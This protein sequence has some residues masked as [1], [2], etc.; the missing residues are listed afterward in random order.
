MENNALTVY[1]EEMSHA[2]EALTRTVGTIYALYGV[3]MPLA[4]GGFAFFGDKQ[5]GDDNEHIPGFIVLFIISTATSYANALWME[6]HQYLRYMY[7]E[8]MP[9]MYSV[10]SIE[11]KPNFFEYLAHSRKKY[12]VAAHGL[13][14]VNRWYGYLGTFSA[15]IVAARI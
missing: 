1:S 5:I 11:G 14:S 6:A 7:L 12:Y 2:R 9:R 8:L 15:A 3:V 4:I 10:A 13:V